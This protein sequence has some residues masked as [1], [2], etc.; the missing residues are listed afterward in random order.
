MYELIRVHKLQ[1]FLGNGG[2]RILIIH[3]RRINQWSSVMAHG[4]CVTNGRV[5]EGE[6]P[7]VSRRKTA[8]KRFALSRYTFRE[9]LPLFECLLSLSLAAQLSGKPHEESCHTVAIAVIH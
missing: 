1:I 6:D 9:R 5:G 7:C 2:V 3:I 8:A 4:A